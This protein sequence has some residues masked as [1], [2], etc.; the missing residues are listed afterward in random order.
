MKYSEAIEYINQLINEISRVNAQITNKGIAS[1]LD[2]DLLLSKVPELYDLLLSLPD[3]PDEL[4]GEKVVETTKVETEVKEVQVEE[5]NEE[6]E[7]AFEPGKETSETSVDDIR[8]EE[9]KTKE[10]EIEE[11]QTV[12]PIA[13]TEKDEEP[14]TSVSEE[15]SEEPE[16]GESKA[17]PEP[18]EEKP[19]IITENAEPEAKPEG[20]PSLFDTLGDTTPPPEDKKPV[21][22]KY[23]KKE[24]SVN[25]KLATTKQVPLAEKVKKTPISDIRSAINL[26]LKLSLIKELFNN[27]QK[28]YKRVIDFIQKCGNYSEAKL[29]VTGEMEKNP[30]WNNH[31]NLVDILMELIERRFR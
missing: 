28:E 31:Q 9:A 1:R 14:D 21:F 17:V 26:N 8:Q 22:E 23:T 15:V 16:A 4:P 7:I 12:E 19:E 30:H 20:Q 13:E 27:D 24:P 3:K 25:E 2:I 11:T 10:P 6:K 29:F 18:G 5:I